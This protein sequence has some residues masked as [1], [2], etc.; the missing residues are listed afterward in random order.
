MCVCVC[1]CV[2][3]CSHVHVHLEFP[4]DRQ[5][6]D[7]NMIHLSSRQC[8]DSLGLLGNLE[9]VISREAFFCALDY[10]TAI[11]ED[12]LKSTWDVTNQIKQSYLLVTEGLIYLWVE[13]YIKSLS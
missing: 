13:C 11:A 9:A 8:Q 12:F 3:V 5:S 4:F 10:T 6:W 1:V 2:C 7:V